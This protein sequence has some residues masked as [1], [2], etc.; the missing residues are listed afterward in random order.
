M[1]SAAACNIRRSLRPLPIADRLAP[2]LDDVFEL[3][4]IL[5]DRVREL[6][7]TGD[8]GQRGLRRAERVG[9]DDMDAEV[10]R[11]CDQ[12]LGTPARSVPSHARVPL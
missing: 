8:A 4:H 2:K 7:T 12:P 3:V 1:P 6:D 10:L 5:S 11:Q 9:R